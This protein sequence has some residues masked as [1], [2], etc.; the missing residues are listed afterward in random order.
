MSI[1]RKEQ[2]S[3]PL[4]ASYASTASYVENANVTTNTGSLLLTASVSSNTITFT[5]GDNISQF[6][7]TVDTGSGGIIN[8]SG[9]V[10][11]SSFNAFTSSINAFTSSYNTGSFSGSFT[12]SLN[13][14]AA[15]ASYYQETDPVF[16]AK[17]ASLATTSSNQF[18]GNQTIT[19]SLIQGLEGNTATGEHS[20]A[21]GSITKAIGNYSHAEGDNTQAIGEYSHA[22]GQETITLAS[23]QYSHAE[24]YGTIASAK[25]QHI[26]GQWNATSSV[27]SAFIV[28]NG[29]DDNN[30]SN[31]IHAA[32]NEVQ[33]SGSMVFGTGG[34]TGSLFGTSSW[35]NNVF[36]AVSSSFSTT[37]SHALNIPQLRITD[38]GA[39]LTVNAASIDF[40]GSGVTATANGNNITVIIPGGSGTPGGTNT[41]IQFNDNNAFSGSSNFT[42]NKNTN[43]VTIQKAGVQ[44]LFPPV[45]TSTTSS[46]IV[47]GN[48]IITGS[49]TTT[50]ANIYT[51]FF[52]QI[53]T[54]PFN[55]SLEWDIG[56]SGS[57]ALVQLTNDVTSFNISY[58]GQDVL[59][60]KGTLIIQQNATGGW[61]F[62]LPTNGG[63][64]TSNLVQDN[65]GGTYNP[66]KDPNAIDILEF[67]CLNKVIF[68]S[69]KYNFT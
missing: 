47:N 58:F 67:I 6:S 30:R 4:S 63:G 13:G 21:E 45:E 3:N 66:T 29:T 32:G 34:I 60:A 52:P 35:A 5:K 65:G 64:N 39:A 8:T 19:G 69:I 9:L 22:E 1:I 28:G 44:N 12:G 7:I 11:T 24:G 54:L 26:Q 15:T 61:N 27:E 23:A 36:Q 49:L 43:L 40:S 50:A 68:W 57:I 48:T 42:F 56:K 46:L 55:A 17:S 59:Y 38:D 10:T 62:T 53:E 18:N 16:V 14:T 33:I 51:E 41:T 2:L 37:A 20:H 31:L 25:W